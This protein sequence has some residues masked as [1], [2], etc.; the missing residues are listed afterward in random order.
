MDA[1]A[2]TKPLVV[3]VGE[4]ASG[5]SAL[6]LELAEKF[7]G[8]IICA[9][10]R[11]VYKGLEIGTAKPS[12]EE[13][14]KVKHHLLDIVE[15]NQTFSAADFKQ[16]A[17]EAIND[18]SS[19]GKIPILVG[20]T[21]LYIDAVL[22]DYGFA[23]A[24]AERDPVNPRHL[25]SAE[26]RQK[27]PLRANTLII[28]LAPERSILKE[29][30]KKRVEVMVGNGLV[31]EARGLGEQYGWDSTALQAPAYKAFREYIEGRIELEEAKALFVKNDLNLAK[32]QRTWF[33]RNN[34]IQWLDDPRKAVEIVT[35]FLSKTAR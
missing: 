9:D 10:S 7:N 18:I 4:T 8:E 27:R 21:G 22:F 31:D 32:R 24:G 30:I 12:S 1:R 5:K 15:P 34:S 17:N 35:T 16:L 26:L 11:T 14:E 28:G 2:R 25:N 23:S 19:R 29:K 33:K 20:G 6:A 13:R 3:V